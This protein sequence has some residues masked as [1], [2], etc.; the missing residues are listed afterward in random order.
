MRKRMAKAD[1]ESAKAE[2]AWEKMKQKEWK[3]TAA[4]LRRK[5]AALEK[6]AKKTKKNRKQVDVVA[7]QD[8]DEE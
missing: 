4:T 3:K 1:R 7:V 2:A 6:K 5:A 8:T